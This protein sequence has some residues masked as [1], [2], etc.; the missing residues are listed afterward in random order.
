MLGKIA[1]AAI[2]F[3]LLIKSQLAFQAAMPIF[4]KK[5]VLQYYNRSDQ[6]EK[7]GFN[8]INGILPFDGNVTR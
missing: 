8:G 2:G 6:F 4:I 5:P 3:V 7:E 1:V